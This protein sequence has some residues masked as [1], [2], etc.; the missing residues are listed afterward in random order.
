MRVRWQL[1]LPLIGLLLFALGSYDS[2][3]M[4]RRAGTTRYQW[5]S[6][7]RLDTDPL[8]QHQPRFMPCKT[9]PQQ[10]CAGWGPVFIWVDP[11]WIATAFMLSAF[12]AFAIGIPIVRGLGHFGG[13]ELVTFYCSMPILIALWFFCAGWLIDFFRLRRVRA[14]E[15][16]QVSKLGSRPAGTD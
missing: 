10:N 7:I 9:D 5:W 2:V 13:N 15:G 12:P 14:K 11:G 6:T 8:E 3:R 4:N 1:L 16:S